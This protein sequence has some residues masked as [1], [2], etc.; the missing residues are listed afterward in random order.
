MAL[1][2]PA[3]PPSSSGEYPPLLPPGLHTMTLDQLHTLCVVGFPLSVERLP[4]WLGLRTVVTTL[5]NS[6]IVGDLWVDG[7]FLTRKMAPRDADVV[8]CLDGNWYDNQSTL[9]HEQ[10]IAWLSTNLKPTL[11]CDSYVFFEFP[12]SHPL[13]DEG[14]YWRDY[15][16]NLYGYDRDQQPKGIAMISLNRGGP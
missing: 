9:A 2:T 5:T 7:S 3:P 1:H 13:H 8:L 15:W 6:G 10:V 11:L 14:V 16:L 4:I 12:A